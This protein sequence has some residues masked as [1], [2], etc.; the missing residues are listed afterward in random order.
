MLFGFTLVLPFRDS[1]IVD[2]DL[3]GGSVRPGKSPS[4][5][6]RAR[7]AAL[8]AGVRE[9]ASWSCTGLRTVATNEVATL[10]TTLG[11]PF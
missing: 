4:G 7:L 10:V 1:R 3:H 11:F 8:E 2:A 9:L 6:Q 5:G